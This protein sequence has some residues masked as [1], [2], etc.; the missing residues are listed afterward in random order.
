MRTLT[1]SD[2]QGIT[3]TKMQQMIPFQFWNKDANRM[4]AINRL[5]GTYFLEPCSTVRWTMTTIK[6]TIGTET[7]NKMPKKVPARVA[8]VDLFDSPRQKKMATIKA[9]ITE[10]QSELS[11]LKSELSDLEKQ[12]DYT[13][14]R[15]VPSQFTHGNILTS[16]DMECL[17]KTDL[18][19]GAPNED[20]K[21]VL[22][23]LN[24]DGNRFMV[25]STTSKDKT[26][27]VRVTELF[28]IKL[29]N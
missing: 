3:A 13:S 28:L 27:D 29:V 4:V 17:Y 6:N 26:M 22:H 9:K 21:C 19:N 5:S 25:G 7:K 20:A 18:V 23:G 15:L 10:L 14:T 12:K 16:Q 2:M 11:T 24:F 8:V 1:P